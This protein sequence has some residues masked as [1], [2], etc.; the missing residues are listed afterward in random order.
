MLVGLSSVAGKRE[1]RIL[2]VMNKI[3]NKTKNSISIIRIIITPFLSSFIGWIIGQFL[4]MPFLLMGRNDPIDSTINHTVSPFQKA[5][6]QNSLIIPNCTAIL[7]FIIGC[8]IIYK[9]I[10]THNKSIH[11]A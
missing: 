2:I 8:Y 9:K 1:V 11:R 5:I 4:A 3:N 7:G 6:A 10:K